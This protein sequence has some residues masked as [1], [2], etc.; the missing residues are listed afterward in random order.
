M[1]LSTDAGEVEYVNE[2]AYTFG[3]SDNP[4]T[5]QF[6][7]NLDAGSRPSSVHGVLL[8]GEPLAVFGANGGATGVHSHAAL[9]LDHQL[10]L[11]I[12][13]RVLCL[14][15]APYEHC[16][17]LR[18]DDATCFGIH[19][20]SPTRSLISH[21]ELQICRFTN[22]G[23]IL[24]QSGGRD[25]FTGDFCLGQSGVIATDFNGFEHRFRYSDGRNDA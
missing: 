3:S 10:L 9:W 20:H 24:W 12:A 14:K 17:T 25:I 7:K 16:W 18:V 22:E 21:G 5:Y 4:R 19:Y 15:L 13:D 6:A 8:N 11:A 1:K 23:R 2:P